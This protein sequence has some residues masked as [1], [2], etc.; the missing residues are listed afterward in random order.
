MKRRLQFSLKRLL[1]AISL[2]C[3][4]LA[5]VRLTFT[6]LESVHSSYLPDAAVLFEGLALAGGSFGTAIGVLMK[7]KRP[8][9]FAL[10][11]AIVSCA[12]GLGW[13]VFGFIAY[14]VLRW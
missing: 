1:Q 8:W 5:V 3:A 2:A 7:T 10:G 12:V 14:F 13:F 6:Y 9:R 4:G 11:G